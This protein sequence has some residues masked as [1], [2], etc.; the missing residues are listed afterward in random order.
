M[1]QQIVAKD[2]SDKPRSL[3][4]TG[5]AATGMGRDSEVDTV[6]GIC[7][8]RTPKGMRGI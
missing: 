2:Q 8:R 5:L 4:L 6:P 3:F 7:P 1:R